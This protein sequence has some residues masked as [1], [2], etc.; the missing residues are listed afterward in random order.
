M[1]PMGARLL[2]WLLTA[3]I[4]AFAALFALLGLGAHLSLG[5][6]RRLAE[7]GTRAEATV[8]ELVAAKRSTAYRVSYRYAAAG[9][10]LD[11]TKRSIPYAMREE[12]RPGARIPV[13][14]DPSQ[15]ERSTTRAELAEMEGWPNRIFFPAV[16]IALLAWGVIRARKRRAA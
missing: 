15:P 4:F 13:W 8:T 14:Y 12:L 6:A 7:S 5:D 11:A 1:I 2:R 16:A 9:R 10:T 3:S